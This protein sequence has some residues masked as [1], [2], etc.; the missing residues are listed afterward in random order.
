[1]NGNQV[2]IDLNEEHSFYSISVASYHMLN[3]INIVA[4]WQFVPNEEEPDLFHFFKIL[5]SNVHRQDKTAY[6]GF[7]CSF[8]EIGSILLFSTI[9]YLNNGKRQTPYSVA[10]VFNSLKFKQSSYIT[11]LINFHL[12]KISSLIHF[13][14]QNT[15]SLLSEMTPYIRDIVL[16]C[17]EFISTGITRPEKFLFSITSFDVSFF[18]TCLQSHLQTQMTTIIEAQSLSECEQLFNFLSFFLLDEQLKMSSQKLNIHPIPGLFLQCMKPNTQQQFLYNELLCFQRPMTI[19]KLANKKVIHCNNFES[20]NRVFQEYS[21]NII[22]E[23][24]LSEEEIFIRLTKLKKEMIFEECKPSELFLT[25]VQEFLKVPLSYCPVLCQQKMSEFVQKAVIIAEVAD[26]MLKQTRTKYLS[27][28]QKS[29]ISELLEISCK[30]E[31]K[32]VCSF[33]QL[34]DE[35]VYNRFYSAR[36]EVIKQMIATI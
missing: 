3:G 36:H 28:Q 4:N 19:I 5:L 23:H 12:K 8:C 9:F 34:F 35:R 1:M 25:F 2:I 13:K 21:D 32:V 6:I 22:N 26:T 31:M 10:F 11:D 29:Q 18:A 20:Q 27:P 17:N 16:S 15:T 30:E 7:P 14:L 24:E 33:A